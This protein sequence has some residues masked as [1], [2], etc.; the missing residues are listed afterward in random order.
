MVCLETMCFLQSL[1]FNNGTAWKLQY[2]DHTRIQEYTDLSMITQYI[3][4]T[5]VLNIKM[6]I[7]TQ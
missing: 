1:Y 7:Y 4:N 6:H 2:I 3:S 5:F